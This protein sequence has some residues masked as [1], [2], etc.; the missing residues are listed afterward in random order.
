MAWLSNIP[1]FPVPADRAAGTY[2]S[3]A[4]SHG[5][6]MGNVFVPEMNALQ[7]IVES[8]ASASAAAIA[9]ANFKGLWSSLSGPLAVPAT[10]VHANQRWLLTESVADV[11]AHT[12]GVS[13]KWLSLTGQVELIGTTNAAGVASVEWTNFDTL[14]GIY[15]ALRIV[16][17]G[18]VGS[19]ATADLK[20]ELRQNG[21]WLTDGS[22][23]YLSCV[24]L[25]GNQGGTGLFASSGLKN[26]AAQAISL[27]MDITGLGRTARPNVRFTSMGATHA[28]GSTATY[29]MYG[30][31]VSAKAWTPT[32]ALQG[33]RI[34]AST[35]NVS[36]TFRLYG[37]RK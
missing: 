25:S 32:T 33:L 6:H 21:A 34:F 27:D 10:V 7:P 2:N 11:T 19:A 30:W 31:T 14:A 18:I 36:G 37:V 1:P 13:S 15:A 26:V 20:G 28:G 3:K 12:P 23:L 5:L 8:A 24:D 22:N 4:V 16:A 35:G 29:A 17:D 9:A